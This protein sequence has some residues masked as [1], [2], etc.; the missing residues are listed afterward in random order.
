MKQPGK[1]LRAKAGEKGTMSRAA[2]LLPSASLPTLL[3]CRP[4][5]AP[6]SGEIK[7]EGKRRSAHITSLPSVRATADSDNIFL[8]K[9]GRGPIEKRKEKG[10]KMRKNQARVR[11]FIASTPATAA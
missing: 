5:S 2:A 10:K 1:A 11:T 9:G 7:A 6:R 8:G 3:H 4:R